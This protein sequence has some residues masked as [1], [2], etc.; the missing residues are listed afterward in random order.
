MINTGVF[1]ASDFAISNLVLNKLTGKISMVSL[2][3][4]HRID[5][6]EL[7]GSGFSLLPYTDIVGI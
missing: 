2:I 1:C 4:S 7:N 5:V 3:T 6:Q